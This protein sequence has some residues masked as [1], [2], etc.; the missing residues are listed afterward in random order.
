[1]PASSHASRELS[2]A[3]LTAVSRAFRGLSNPRRW[4]FFAKNSLT[5][6][7][8]CFSAMLSA[9]TRRRG[10][11]SSVS[12][13]PGIHFGIYDGQLWSCIQH[14]P[15]LSLKCMD[16]LKRLFEQHFHSPAE[17]VQPLQGQ[18]GG[19]GRNIFRVSNAT[20]TAIGILYP[21]REE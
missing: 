21:V 13:S 20:H 10:C 5:E 3:S 17:R 11:L 4:R 1:M 7:S 19:S 2:T 12:I 14:N 15:M 9:V 18:L 16:V 8:R 6:M